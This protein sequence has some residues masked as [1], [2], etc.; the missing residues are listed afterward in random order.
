MSCLFG[1]T[2]QGAEGGRKE[3]SGFLSV[4]EVENRKERVKDER[5]ESEG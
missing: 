2:E 1:G 3:A 5:R 4:I